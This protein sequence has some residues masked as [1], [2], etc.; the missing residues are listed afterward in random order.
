LALFSTEDWTEPPTL[1]SSIK[2]S[3]KTIRYSHEAVLY[4]RLGLEEGRN[5]LEVNKSKELNILDNRCP[6]HRTIKY[7]VNKNWV[8]VIDA[9]MTVPVTFDL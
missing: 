2:C 8:T 4:S 9:C 5:S 6:L 3:R 7:I 1:F